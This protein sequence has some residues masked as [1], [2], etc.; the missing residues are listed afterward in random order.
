MMADIRR[1]ANDS[2]FTPTKIE[3]G[4]ALALDL[5]GGFRFIPSAT[6]DSIARTVFTE[7]GQQM[8]LKEITALAGG[9]AAVFTSC[10]RMGNLIRTEVNMVIGDSLTTQKYGIGYDLMRLRTEEGRPLPD[11]AILRAMQ[12]AI[13]NGW[14]N[15][16]LYRNAPEGLRTRP[17]ELVAVG[18]ITFV[19]ST[20]MP[21][22][23]L[24]KDKIAVSYDIV[25]TIVHEC[26]NDSLRT[27]VDVESRDVM[28]ASA[29]L[30]MTEN[31]N[32]IT[33]TELGILA[34]YEVGFYITGTLTRNEKGA[35]LNLQYS[36][37][38][39]NMTMIPLL[40]SSVPVT[41]DSKV[42]IRDA[43]R[44]AVRQMFGGA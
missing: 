15:D 2:L 7:R 13:C 32:P 25:E 43:V 42:A 16:T 14:E 38:G 41:T 3:A 27:V 31:Y 34:K 35:T 17:T 1:D 23:N 8:S 36:R 24:F 40:R 18:G 37:L 44:V 29:G 9:K 39:P 10:L 4:L 5:A 26:A 6:R 12:R 30:Y 19:D 28:Y 33:E 11:P 20:S 22:W 21:Q